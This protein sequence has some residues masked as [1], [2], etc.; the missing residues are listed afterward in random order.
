MAEYD[1]AI[2]GSSEN[3]ERTGHNCIIFRDN[4]EGI[5][6]KHGKRSDI[7]NAK[8]GIQFRQLQYIIETTD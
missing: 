7:Y 8:R 6:E 4:I 5:G 2:S 3:R 1:A